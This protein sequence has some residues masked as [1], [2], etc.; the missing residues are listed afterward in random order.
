MAVV[1]G[2]ITIADVIDG[3]AG[4]NAVLSNENHTFVAAADGSIADA[5]LAMFN[6]NVS[7]F[8][9]TTAL[10]FA[11]TNSP[12]TA[13][14]FAISNGTVNGAAAIG[15][16]PS[17]AG[18]T[19]AVSGVGLITVTNTAG[20]TGFAD[21]GDINSVVLNVP[22]RIQVD[23]GVFRTI[24]KTISFAKSVGGSA[25]FVRLTANRQTVAYDNGATVPK[26]G[27]GNLVFTSVAPNITEG[28][29]SWSFFSG[30]ATAISTFT[31][32]D[33][34][35]TGVTITSSSGTL[36]D[37]LTVTPAAYDTLLANNTEVV[38]R[39]SR[40]MA[41]DQITVIMIEDAAPGNDSVQVIIQPN[42]STI[43]RN[44]T[45]S[46]VLTAILYE[47]GVIVPDGGSPDRINSYQWQQDNTNIEAAD[48]GTAR[49]LTVEAD[50]IANDGASLY[51]C[52]IDYD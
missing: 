47:G 30:N 51:A 25:E 31:A 20:S 13:M 19:V 38:F 27:E 44:N 40:G 34:T 24:N 36:N 5:E 39:S 3:T 8:F 2:Y 7:A 21:A 41:N 4:V 14:Q 52:I 45:G 35:E 12:T 6:T 11:A 50:D 23:T 32:L 22:V 26:S 33:G 1:T 18:L 17:N 46:V 42:G 29:Y 49:T 9:G 15:I 43:F 48:G 28:S 37:I 10:T 16:T